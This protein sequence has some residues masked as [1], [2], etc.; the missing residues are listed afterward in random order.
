[1]PHT[2]PDCV[3]ENGPT[4]GLQHDLGSALGLRSL[5]GRGLPHTACNHTNS[6]APQLLNLGRYIRFDG[7]W[8]LIGEVGDRQHEPQASALRCCAASMPAIVNSK[9]FTN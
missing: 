2:E 1:M 6:T 9:A 5:L 3:Q 7:T 8:E 4:K